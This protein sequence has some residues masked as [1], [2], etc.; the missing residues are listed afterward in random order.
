M[1]LGFRGCRSSLPDAGAGEAQ[2]SCLAAKTNTPWVSGG[3]RSPGF[4]PAS[5]GFG[6]SPG[7]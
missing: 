5:A 2:H 1:C 3:G 6:L 7:T 4:S